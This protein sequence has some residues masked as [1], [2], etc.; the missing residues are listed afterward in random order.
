[1]ES[2]NASDINNIAPSRDDNL[3]L[4][5]LVLLTY[6]RLEY[7]KEALQSALDQTYPKL[8]IIVSDNHSEKNPQEIVES[9]CDPRVHFHRNPVNVGQT[10]NYIVSAKMAH[11]KYIAFLHDD[12]KLDKDFISKLVA[13]FLGEP[14]AVLTFCDHYVMNAEGVIDL[15]LTEKI[16]NYY[17]TETGFTPG[18]H[19]PFYR[20][21]LVT[22]T[23]SGMDTLFC[24]DAI[25]WD[26]IPTD[27]PSCCDLY[28]IYL[29]SLTGRGA[30]YV[31][32]KLLYY[33][34]HS[35]QA[36]N[37]SVFPQ[38]MVRCYQQ[39]LTDKRLEKFWPEFKKELV[40][41]RTLLGIALIKENR[42]KEAREQ[43]QKAFKKRLTVRG[44]AAI[45]LTYIPYPW[46]AKAIA[47]Y[48]AGRK[49]LHLKEAVD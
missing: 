10:A 25:N 44:I 20:R 8:E 33:R 48:R 16:I 49:R 6:N 24:R 27:L 21:G 15:A 4:V 22:R 19:K 2:K 11:G 23:I 43:L 39:F 42:P 7:L 26:D 17:I 14:Q 1:M 38:G 40:K 46:T 47:F 45:A 3:P 5:S 28:M 35:G 41:R 34:V 13:P 9:F 30:Y 29:Y 37:H 32:E 36:T 31:P 12:D 18:L